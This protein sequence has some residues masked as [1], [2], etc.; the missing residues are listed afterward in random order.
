MA[1]PPTPL[2]TGVTQIAIAAEDPQKLAAFYTDV[3]GLERLFDTG[4]MI[5]LR[6]GAVRLMIGARQPE[7]KIGG[8]AV[9]YFEPTVWGTTEKALEA[10]GVAFLHP[11]VSLMKAEG[12]ELA[13]RAF[14]D[15]EGHTLALFGWRAA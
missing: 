2:V 3:L 12:R 5:F 7:Q 4:G 11:A 14:N 13:L 1:A 8:D 15:P 10:A 9:F 6:A